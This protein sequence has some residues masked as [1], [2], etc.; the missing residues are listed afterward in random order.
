MK[1]RELNFPQGVSLHLE[2]SR[3]ALAA[4]LANQ[5]TEW[6][7][8]ALAS[9][10]R[11]LLVVSGGS[12][13][14]KFFEALS[15]RSLDWQRVD[16]TLADERW[17][18]EDHAASNAALVKRHLMVG[19]VA[20]ANFVALKTPET[21]PVNAVD[22]LHAELSNL[23]WPIDVLI[24]GMGNDGHTASLFPGTVGLPNAMSSVLTCAA[25]TP[26]DAPHDRMTLS[27]PVL[28]AAAHSVL[29]IVGDDKSATMANV[30]ADLDAVEDM[31]VR[32]FIRAGLNIFWSS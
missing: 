5:V 3:D 13:P 30:L 11:A 6:L 15:R 8:E 31:P 4:A 14:L 29:H 12:T 22:N 24:L 21:D 10:D 7:K 26:L 28:S 20:E 1:M 19:K 9:K 23:S 18:D 2:K 32:G 27:Y 16:I 25:V 17:V